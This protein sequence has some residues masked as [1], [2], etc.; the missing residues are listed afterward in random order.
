MTLEFNENGI[1]YHEHQQ[2]YLMVDDGILE[3]QRVV[4]YR[5]CNR[6]RAD[7]AS[8]QLP[9][10]SKHDCLLCSKCKYLFLFGQLPQNSLFPLAGQGYQIKI[11]ADHDLLYS[12]CL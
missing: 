6:I 5:R 9:D 1:N 2:F 12:S 7:T 3:N 4:F 8:K 11:E 10:P